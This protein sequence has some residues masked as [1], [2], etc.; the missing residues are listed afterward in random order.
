MSALRGSGVDDWSDEHFALV[1]EVARNIFVLVE[2]FGERV[3]VFHTLL[4]VVFVLSRGGEFGPHGIDQVV[5]I[6][7]GHVGLR[8]SLGRFGC[9]LTE[10]ESSVYDL[11]LFARDERIEVDQL[12]RSS[13]ED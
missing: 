6:L 11:L 13:L 3:A 8:L 10:T 12:S 4:P 9:L 2:T 7:C 1:E 5:P